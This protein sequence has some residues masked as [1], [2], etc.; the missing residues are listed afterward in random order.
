MLWSRR[1]T[2]LKK[3]KFLLIIL[4][5]FPS[6]SILRAQ[7]LFYPTKT[8]VIDVNIARNKYFK[9]NLHRITSFGGK[10]KIKIPYKQEIKKDRKLIKLDDGQLCQYEWTLYPTGVDVTLHPTKIL[11][12]EYDF[13]KKEIKDDKYDPDTSKWKDEKESDIRKTDKEIKDKI[14]EKDKKKKVNPAKI[15]APG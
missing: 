2:I 10:T 6:I 11:Y 4:L 5:L 15:I 14:K 12:R 1:V 8:I 7:S 9:D 13:K 3:I